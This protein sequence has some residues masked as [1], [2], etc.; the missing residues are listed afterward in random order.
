MNTDRPKRAGHNKPAQPIERKPCSHCDG[1]GHTDPH[2]EAVCC[3][4]WGLQ[5]IE[6][7]E[8]DEYDET[9]NC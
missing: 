3:H 9:G 4:C 7:R 5:T 1:K 8:G 6:V 2:G